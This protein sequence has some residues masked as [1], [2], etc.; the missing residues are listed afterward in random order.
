MPSTGIIAGP[1]SCCEMTI[2]VFAARSIAARAMSA[3]LPA[4]FG[5]THA[6][7]PTDTMVA[8]PA[9]AVAGALIGPGQPSSIEPACQRLAHTDQV[10]QVSHE[11]FAQVHAHSSL[12]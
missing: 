7:R 11:R 3:S 12:A 10:V 8:S 9:D 4:F 1:K 6:R 2:L 5:S